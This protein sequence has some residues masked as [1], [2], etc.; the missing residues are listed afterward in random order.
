MIN[1]TEKEA[2]KQLLRVYN[3]FPE[4]YKSDLEEVEALRR[5]MDP[6]TMTDVDHWGAF[7]AEEGTHEEMDIYFLEQD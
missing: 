5:S 4:S 7:E 6:G 2:Y 3:P 1:K